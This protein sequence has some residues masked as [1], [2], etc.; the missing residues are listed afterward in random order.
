MSF[1]AQCAH[2]ATKNYSKTFIVRS[3]EIGKKTWKKS[4]WN[5]SNYFLAKNGT[6][7]TYP[8]KRLATWQLGT[9]WP[10]FTK[11]PCN[12]WGTAWVNNC[13]KL[14]EVLAK[15]L[16]LI[17]C[18]KH[19]IFTKLQKY[20]NCHI[21]VWDREEGTCIVCHTITTRN[22]LV[23]VAFCI[24]W[25]F[26]MYVKVDRILVETLISEKQSHIR[27]MISENLKIHFNLFY[28]KIKNAKPRKGDRMR[29]K[30]PV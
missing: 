21:W 24:I 2:Y 6:T 15:M 12:R 4:F 8:I 14:C 29:H 27:F 16:V 5:F 23:V 28:E 9:V 30:V 11:S 18:H 3:Y 22:K 25:Y 7:L 17:S 10:Y 13:A 26:I 19:N 20:T 1:N